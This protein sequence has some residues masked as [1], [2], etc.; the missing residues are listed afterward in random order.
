MWSIRDRLSRKVKK[1][2]GWPLNIRNTEFRR[3]IT[4]GIVRL[5]FRTLENRGSPKIHEDQAFISYVADVAIVLVHVMRAWLRSPL[6]I[7]IPLR[8]ITRS[9]AESVILRRK[10]NLT[11]S[12]TRAPPPRPWTSQKL[13]V[14]CARFFCV[15]ARIEQ[16]ANVASSAARTKDLPAILLDTSCYP[17]PRN[18]PQ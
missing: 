8:G 16:Q 17:G 9:H 2:S 5:C 10:A 12:S 3:R 11:E 18:S 14:T 4:R 6:L 13:R 1:G 15:L 7:P